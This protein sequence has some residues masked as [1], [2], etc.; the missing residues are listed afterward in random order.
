MFRPPAGDA[1]LRH[2]YTISHVRAFGWPL[3]PGR[4][5]TSRSKSTSGSRSPGTRSSSTS[6]P[7]TS[8]PSFPAC[9][10]PRTRS[11]KTCSSS[12]AFTAVLAALTAYDDYGLAAAALGRC[13]RSSRPGPLRAGR[14]GDL[15]APCPSRGL[16]TAREPG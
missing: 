13:A 12:T 8:P 6:T 11:A 2:G 15:R 1:H 9:S 7:A 5:G 3:S 10:A 14:A 4:P 16:A